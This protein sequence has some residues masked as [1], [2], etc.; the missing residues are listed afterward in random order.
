[1]AQFIA[2]AGGLKIS[3]VDI[4]SPFANAEDASLKAFE[5]FS[6]WP[7]VVI[8]IAAIATLLWIGLLGW[9]LARVMRVLR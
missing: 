2:D 3:H 8:G 4:P 5:L 9:L 7:A 6:L 1:M